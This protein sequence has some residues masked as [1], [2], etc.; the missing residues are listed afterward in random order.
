VASIHK[1]QTASGPRYEVRHR[2]N[3][4]EVSRT[5]K[6]R[7]EADTYRRNV[8][9]ADLVGLAVDPRGAKI[10]FD[11]WW[12]QWW[13]ST[14]HL[15]ASS[16]ARDESCWRSRIKPTLGD[17]PLAKLDRAVLRA[18]VAELDDAG[19]APTTVHK[20]AQIVSK[21]LRAAVDDGRLARNP[22]ERLELPRVERG[23]TRFLT[24]AEVMKL[25]DK[26]D[27]A[28]RALVI[29]GAYGGLRL[30]EMLA[31]RPERIDLLRG[32]VEVLATLGEVRGKLV[33]NPPKTRA[34]RRTV[35]LPRV[36]VE[37]LTD[38]L[39]SV[40]AGGYVFT[41]PEGGPVWP[42]AW[43]KRSWHPAV[44]AAKL[45]PLRP[46]DLRHTAVAFWI[47]AG[48]SPNE[49]AARAGHSSVVTVLDRYGHLLPDT[50][51]RVT[52][53]L[54]DLARKAAEASRSN[55]VAIGTRDMRGMPG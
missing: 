55:V 13:P 38:H 30:G 15:R 44:A 40:R 9:H 1:R 11:A 17:V 32:R 2:V 14:L 3:G 16:R 5:F 43:R 34:G 47:A 10:T 33:E 20:A 48:A 37:A 39:E 42:R 49:I 51:E 35:P 23:E 28:Y 52:S 45:A 26:I 46:H 4:R 8:E 25:A 19:L 21:A 31:L 7:A 22:A 24:P 29:L 27:P 6:R 12:E 53:A 18:W 36:A 54:D 41:G 50:G